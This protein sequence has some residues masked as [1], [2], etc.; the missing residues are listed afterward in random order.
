MTAYYLL[1]NTTWNSFIPPSLP[2]LHSAFLPALYSFLYSSTLYPPL[3]HSYSPVTNLM[4]LSRSL[5]SRLSLIPPTSPLFFPLFLTLFVGHLW[6]MAAC[7]LMPWSAHSPA[8]SDPVARIRRKNGMPA[9]SFNHFST[10]W[11][12]DVFFLSTCSLISS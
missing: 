12:S 6:L 4:H 10:I 7:P 9:Y 1:A 2:S 11:G 8:R 3:P 5:P